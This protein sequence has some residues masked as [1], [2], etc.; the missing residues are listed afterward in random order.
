MREFVINTSNGGRSTG[1]CGRS[2][3]GLDTQLFKDVFKVLVDGAMAHAQDVGNV[4]VGFDL[5]TDKKSKATA[6]AANNNTMFPSKCP[7][8]ISH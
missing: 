5:A 7:W 8:M 3:T 4:S 1:Q 2:G 6:T